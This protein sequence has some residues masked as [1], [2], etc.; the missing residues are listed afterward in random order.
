MTDMLKYSQAITTDVGTKLGNVNF[1]VAPG[2]RP[3]MA[4]GLALFKLVI[5]H[6]Q[7]VVVLAGAEC[8]SPALALQRPCFEAFSR[9]TWV[10]WCLT[11]HDVTEILNAGV[12]YQFP[13]MKE[14]VTKIESNSIFQSGAFTHV[15]KQTWSYWCDLTH[16][17]MAQVTNQWP[18][19][20]VDRVESSHDPALIQQALHWATV[21][22]LMSAIQLTVDAGEE[23]LS[24]HF[25][26]LLKSS[27][28]T[29]ESMP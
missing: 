27:I 4:L 5:D 15:K 3:R 11:D 10:R 21:W 26:K 19:G 22:Q 12:E 29:F 23:P 24:Q 16:G 28:E 1:H 8:Y 17:G 14:L 6:C 13:S 18:E 7:G 25:F 2:S 20:K 9:G